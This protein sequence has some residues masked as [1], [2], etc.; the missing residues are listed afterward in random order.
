MKLARRQETVESAQKQLHKLKHSEAASAATEFETKGESTNC[1]ESVRATGQDERVDK[2]E[3]L[4]RQIRQLSEEM[5]KL[6]TPRKSGQR[7]EGWKD[8]VC[9]MCGGHGHGRRNCPNKN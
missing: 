5:E 2:I 6:R 1:F 9:W 7:P 4:S 8:M 3:E